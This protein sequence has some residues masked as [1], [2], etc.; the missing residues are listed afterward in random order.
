MYAC[1][2]MS[3]S[4]SHCSLFFLDNEKLIGKK[5]DRDLVHSRLGFESN[6]E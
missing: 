3:F 1:E 5:I 4:S 6:R 2:Q